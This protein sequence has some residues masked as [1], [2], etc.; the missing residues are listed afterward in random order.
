MSTLRVPILVMGLLLLLSSS[1]SFGAE[2][3]VNGK[4]P[5]TFDQIQQHFNA[6]S[7]QRQ[8]AFAK[9]L[10]NTFKPT[11]A[12]TA[13]TWESYLNEKVVMIECLDGGKNIPM[14]SYTRSGKPIGTIWRR[15]YPGEQF[16]VRIDQYT[17]AKNDANLPAI[18][19]VCLNQKGEFQVEKPEPPVVEEPPVVIEP[20]AVQFPPPLPVLNPAPA[21]G[22]G[23][24]STGF[25]PPTVPL[26]IP[27]G[28]F[29]L[30]QGSG[31]AASAATSVTVINQ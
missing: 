1:L 6:A 31:S 24:G 16:I 4:A 20:P 17:D 19:N 14:H 5:K 26:L 25:V 27:N 12:V 7:P 23:Y 15:C 10:N 11:V 22:P 9:L 21:G 3:F 2:P 30:N 13:D 29:R 8:A 28:V 18:S